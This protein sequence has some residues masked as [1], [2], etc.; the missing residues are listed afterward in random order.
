VDHLYSIWMG[1]AG[2]RSQLRRFHLVYSGG[3]RLARTLDAEEALDAFESAQHCYVAEAARSRL[4]VHAGVVGWGDRAI[5][6]PG[7]ALAGK[8]TLVAALVRAGGTYYS[9][10][11][12]VLDARGR[13]H[14]YPTPLS[15]REP[16]S[17]RPRKVP[18]AA[19]GGS[20][21]LPPLPVGLVL[22]TYYRQGAPWR[23]R[24]LSA[25]QAALAL[26]A[27]TVA[28]RRRPSAALA[29]LRRVASQA[30]AIRGV[31][32]EADNVARAILDFQR[33]GAPAPRPAARTRSGV[34]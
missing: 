17:D 28:A 9:D 34:R 1:G 15:V 32:G 5:V 8:T 14:P 26:L 12:A 24:P 7:R 27:N 3:V 4:F 16:G 13:V 21:G 11:Y 31:R 29:T 20:P 10:E 19:L 23:P 2:P 6:I 33:D 30:P 18:A 25:G 22:V